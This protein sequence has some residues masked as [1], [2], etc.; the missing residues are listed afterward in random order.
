MATLKS[1]IVPR[2]GTAAAW[3][4]A[5]PVLLKGE[6]GVEVDTRRFKFGD[7]LTSWSDLPY[8]DKHLS[9]L[10]EAEKERAM[11]EEDALLFNITTIRSMLKKGAQLSEAKAALLELGENY[12]DLY[13]VATTL[14]SFL[15]S[16]DTA[17]ETINKWTE[18]EQFLNGITDT[19]SLAGLLTELETK[20]TEAYTKEIEEKLDAQFGDNIFILDGGTPEGWSE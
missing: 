2:N 10:I 17:D 8:A 18:L 1:R 11:A 4:E 6:I 5:N 16:T 9:D 20:I 14:K 15:E 12:K 7:G 19:E 3:A 13:S